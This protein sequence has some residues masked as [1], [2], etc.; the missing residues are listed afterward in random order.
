MVIAAVSHA[1]DV[2]TGGGG[3][4]LY[5]FPHSS[6]RYK[7]GSSSQYPYSLA[8]RSPFLALHSNASLLL[9]RLSLFLPHSPAV[10]VHLH[11]H[12]ASV[13]LANHPFPPWQ[14]EP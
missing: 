2:V 8:N 11:S 6:I 13:R 1:S 7:S 12:L 10:S 14:S 4:G 9:S 5:H 3:R